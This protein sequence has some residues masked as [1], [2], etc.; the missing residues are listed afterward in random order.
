MADRLGRYD[1]GVPDG[2]DQQPDIDELVGKQDA[3][4]IGETRLGLDRAGGGVDLVV[5]GRQGPLGEAGGARAVQSRGGQHRAGPQTRG[6]LGHGILRQ[7]EHH[8]H[9]VDLGDDDQAIGRAAG[10]IVAGIHLAQPDPPGDRGGDVAIVDVQPGVGDGGL[11]GLDH[12]LVLLDQGRLGVDLL[13]GD[14]VLGRQGAVTLQVQPRIGQ[15]R[16]VLQQLALRLL[17]GDHIGPVVDLGQALARPDHLAF[18][19]VDPH[20]IAGDARLHDHAGRG[21]HRAQ[22]GELDG[23]VVLLRRGHADHA[24]RTPAAASASRRRAGAA[25]SGSGA[26]GRGVMRRQQKADKDHRHHGQGDPQKG[27][28]GGAL[29]RRRRA[30]GIAGRRRAGRR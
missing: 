10:H 8:V 4:T 30:I 9:G 22:G 18:L 29:A 12:A 1:D 21:G 23:H 6:D 25:A 26:L 24:R 16:L 14:G 5:E 2:V 3:G 13:L 7:G 20:Q 19:E 27:A 17:Q 11:V 28:P 15:G